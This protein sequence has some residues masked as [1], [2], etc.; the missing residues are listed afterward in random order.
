MAFSS[1]SLTLIGWFGSLLLNYGSRSSRSLPAHQRTARW[2]LI[3]CSASCG[4]KGLHAYHVHICA[5]HWSFQPWLPRDQTACIRFVCRFHDGPAL[6]M[7]SCPLRPTEM[8]QHPRAW[9][10]W[11]GCLGKTWC[12]GARRNESNMVLR[13]CHMGCRQVWGSRDCNSESRVSR[14]GCSESWCLQ[15]FGLPEGLHYHWQHH[16]F[17]FAACYGAGSGLLDRRFLT[18]FLCSAYRILQLVTGFRMEFEQVANARI[19]QRILVG[20]AWKAKPTIRKLLFHWGQNVRW[21]YVIA[22]QV[23]SCKHVVL[24]CVFEVVFLV[25]RRR[26][27]QDSFKSKR[28]GRSAET[29]TRS[30]SGKGRLNTRILYITLTYTRCR[31]IL[32]FITIS[33]LKCQCS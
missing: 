26:Q 1:V 7:F 11:P 8:I 21:R 27:G 10:A 19:N 23:A 14:E 15:G 4:F 28:F 17:P 24:G 30:I 32:E 33:E 13:R 20:L 22:T 5:L 25:D 2:Q 16:R 6:R 18:L 3:R 9:V 12:E 29:C 31:N